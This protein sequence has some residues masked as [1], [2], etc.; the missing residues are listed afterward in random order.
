MGRPLH[1]L[2]DLNFKYIQ[3]FFHLL[4]DFLQ[5]RLQTLLELFSLA[6]DSCFKKEYRHC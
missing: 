2:S 3:V 1:F 6:K 5:N 4:P